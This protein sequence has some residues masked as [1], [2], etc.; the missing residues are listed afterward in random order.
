MLTWFIEQLCSIIHHYQFQ[1]IRLRLRQK[2]LILYYCLL[3]SSGFF[4]IIRLGIEHL[5]IYTIG[6]EFLFYF[7]RISYTK[8]NFVI[9]ME[10]LFFIGSL[11]VI[12]LKPVTTSHFRYQTYTIKKICF[13]DRRRKPLNSMHFTESFWSNSI[14]IILLCVPPRPISIL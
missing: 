9:S 5:Y 3:S 10:E 1:L 14:I 11:H 7:I 6:T 13:V 4:L 2:Y 12:N 8:N